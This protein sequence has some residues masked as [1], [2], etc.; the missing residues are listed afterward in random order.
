MQNRK[1]KFRFSGTLKFFI[2]NFKIWY[3]QLSF[4]EEIKSVKGFFVLQILFE[5]VLTF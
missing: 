5:R 4:C 2:V 3:I 1:K